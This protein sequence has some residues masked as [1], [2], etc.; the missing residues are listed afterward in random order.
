[1]QA[2]KEQLDFLKKT[3]AYMPFRRIWRKAYDALQD[4]LWNEVLNKQQFTTLGAARFALDIQAIQHVVDLSFNAYHGKGASLTM[5][6]LVEGIKLL[7]LPLKSD[8]GVSL[9]DASDVVFDTGSADAMLE[10]L[11]LS[12]LSRLEARVILQ[13]RMELNE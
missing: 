1:M 6:K 8:G 9:Q 7:N 2:L 5:P 11:Q 4:L 3:L 13:S 12:R 10:K